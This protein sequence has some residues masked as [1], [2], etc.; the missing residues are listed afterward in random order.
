MSNTRSANII[1]RVG[2]N[3]WGRFSQECRCLMHETWVEGRDFRIYDIKKSKKFKKP[4]L[5]FLIQKRCITKYSNYLCTACNA[6][7]EKLLKVDCEEIK[8]KEQDEIIIN[9]HILIMT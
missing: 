9:K 6:A 7:A 2:R 4:V 5:Q 8:E 1:D 3:R